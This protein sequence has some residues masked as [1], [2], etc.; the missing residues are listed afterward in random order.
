MLYETPRSP[1]SDLTSQEGKLAEGLEAQTKQVFEN[2]RVLLAAAGS[3]MS[4]VVKA[5]VF[6]RAGLLLLP[7]PPYSSLS[8]PL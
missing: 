5:T 1:K 8:S 3:D 2:I 6:V 7:P 4:Q